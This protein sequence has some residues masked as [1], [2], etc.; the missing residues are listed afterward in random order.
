MGKKR[1]I[2]VAA[3][4]LAA[5]G[6]IVWILCLEG[7]PEPVYQGKRLSTL[8]EAPC[9]WSAGYAGT[10]AT[11]WD[12][13]LSLADEA[14]RHLGTNAI[15]TLLRMVRARDSTIKVKLLELAAKLPLVK[16]RHI[17]AP[18][19][20]EYGGRGFELLGPLA[21]EAVPEL[22]QIY[23]ANRSPASR[24]AAIMA[25]GAIGPASKEAVPALLI[26]ASNTRAFKTPELENRLEAISAL[27]R[28][29]A[30]PDL[31][32]PTL[33]RLLNDRDA[34]IRTAAILSLSQYGADAKS[35]IPKLSELSNDQ[36]LDLVV[37]IYAGK[38]VGEIKI[39]AGIRDE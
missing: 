21:K 27:G 35:A 8:M 34:K 17:P 37:R 29:H 33:I 4:I 9:L 18:M 22:I 11:T 36:D 15:P 30:A 32:V 12:N 28:I 14:I 2:L 23:N 39:A 19:I 26:A 25:L 1:R 6:G 38:A 24:Y 13:D 5:L 16:F 20:N 10:N 3:L 31:V 7:K